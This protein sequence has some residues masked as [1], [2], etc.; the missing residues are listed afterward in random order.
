[1]GEVWVAHHLSLGEDVALKVLSRFAPDEVES[2]STASAR[3]HFE[4]KVAARLSRK[5]RHIVRVTDHGEE[6]D[7]A[8]L[9]MELLD[10]ETLERRI[11]RRGRLT[12]SEGVGLVA[13]LARALTEAHAEGVIHRD[14]K[15]SNVFVTTD[16]D[17]GPLFKLLDFG[18][19][20]TIHTHSAQ[21]A[22]SAFATGRG[23]IFGTPGYMSPE[24]AL[25]GCRL[26]HHCDL[27]SLATVAYEAL[28]GELPV[29]GS[30]P[31]ELV[32]NLRAGRW[33][34][35]H[36][37]EPT[38]PLGLR[39]FFGRAFASAVDERYASAS[40]LAEAFAIAVERGADPGIPGPVRR[41][42]P[43]T[44]SITFPMRFRRGAAKSHVRESPGRGGRL[45]FAASLA[46]LI[47][48]PVT[49][50]ASHALR[51]V[52]PTVAIAPAA[53]AFEYTASTAVFP[54]R[55][56]SGEA[57]EPPALARSSAAPPLWR[58]TPASARRG[59]ATTTEPR[60]AEAPS[61]P[62][63]TPKPFDKSEIL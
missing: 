44:L 1:M 43:R 26:D 54:P 14:L 47:G 10:G 23:L 18:I 15:P 32:A 21:S 55:W 38:L 42:A 58:N 29:A 46:L 63:P 6:E 2:P 33:V 3:F 8:Y 39:W 51:S 36:E 60:P 37:R 11:S 49:Q 16:E 4:A 62:P 28:T 20:R 17:G 30:L 61:S 40:E 22:A 35:V 27:W 19:A 31:H 25:P 9:V 50:V 52:D 53:S 12:P 41:G 59:E 34:P 57:S 48:A 5:T 45:L 13:Q 56:P 24:Q 7:L